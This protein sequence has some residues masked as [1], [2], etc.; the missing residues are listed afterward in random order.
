MTDLR[1]LMFQAMSRLQW[2][3]P[4]LL[5]TPII[6]SKHRQRMSKVIHPVGQT[7]NGSNNVSVIRTTTNTVVATVPVRDGPHGIAVLPNGNYVYAANEL[8]NNVSVIRTTDNVI[9]ATIP[10][11]NGPVGVAALPNSNYVYVTNFHDDNVAVIR[12]VDNTVVARI[13]VGE[14]PWGITAL[15]D[16]NYVFVANWYSNNVMVIGR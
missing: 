7:A 2:V 11:G 14:A 3:I 1:A 8:S 13:S 4:S 5:L 15:P 9:V 12:T 16:G 10:V 6:M